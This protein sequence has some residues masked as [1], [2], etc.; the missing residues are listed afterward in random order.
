MAGAFDDLQMRFNRDHF[1]RFAKFLH[2]AKGIAR[3]VNKECGNAQGSKVICSK[4]AG[5]A[6][7]M[8]RI[9]QQ[10]KTVRNTSIVRGYHARLPAA[11]R[12]SGETKGN[13]GS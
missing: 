13:P 6:W 2:G 4:L 11:I 3:P 8:Q 9:R 7:W 10:Q 5:F 1:D 12:M